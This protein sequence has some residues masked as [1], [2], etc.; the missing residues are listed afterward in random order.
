MGTMVVDPRE[1]DTELADI[2]E[3]SYQLQHYLSLHVDDMHSTLG[4]RRKY[5]G[6]IPYWEVPASDTV[7]LFREKVESKTLMPWEQSS[8][9]RT[10][11][12]F[13][14]RNAVLEKLEDRSS[15]LEQ[16][17][18]AGPWLRFFLVQNAGGHIHSSM[19]C[20]TCRP[21]TRFGWL[22][23]LSGKTEA[24]A[25]ADQGPLLCTVCFPSAPVE[26]TV[27]KQKE[28]DESVCTGSSMQGLDVNWKSYSPYGTCPECRQSMGVTSTGKI[29]RHKKPSPR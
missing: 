8:A 4:H 23:D 21:T 24:E 13:D 29:R 25:V 19:S 12:Q 10:L 9:E 2:Y 14:A 15:D 1:I 26:W 11:E 17:F 27:G 28:V 5:H 18:R 6:A 16:I 20:S 3:Q 7:A 22:P